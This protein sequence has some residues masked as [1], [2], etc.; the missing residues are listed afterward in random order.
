MGQRAGDM[1]L[2]G[3]KGEA[4]QKD[5]RA[6]AGGTPEGEGAGEHPACGRWGEEG[7]RS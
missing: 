7:T 6:S 5:D 1:S 4:Y 2:G 3:Q